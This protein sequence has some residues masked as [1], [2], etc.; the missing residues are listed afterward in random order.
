M[1]APAP[2]LT[3]PTRR[4]PGSWGRPARLC[5]SCRRPRPRRR[6]G[7]RG[8]RRACASRPLGRVVSIALSCWVPS[9][10]LSLRAKGVKAFAVGSEGAGGE[11]RV[12]GS[13]CSAR[14]A[15]ASRSGP[16]SARRS[17]GPGA[18]AP[19]GADHGVRVALGGVGAAGRGRLQGRVRALE[20]L[21]VQ[22]F[23]RQLGVVLEGRGQLARA[24]SGSTL[25]GSLTRR[26]VSGSSIT[27]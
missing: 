27:R 9:A 24:G 23:D 22:V 14:Q 3:V 6:R 12:V 2:T 16:G 13:R 20:E 11:G 8:C 7:S 15:G 17:F 21:Q 19:S 4:R 18:L 25:P 1:P 10:R 5:R 26:P